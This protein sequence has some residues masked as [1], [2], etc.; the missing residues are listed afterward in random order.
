MFH[1]T[2][3]K[4]SLKTGELYTMTSKYP[5]HA[6]LW[7]MDGVLVNT[8]ELHYR[9]WKLAFDEAG[10]S[11]SQKKFTATFGMNNA[12]ILETVFGEDLTPD[13]YEKISNRKETSFRKMVKGNAELLPGADTLLEKFKT[14]SMKQAIAS[15]APQENI[16]VLVGE[17]KIGGYFDALISGTGMPGKPDPA[18]FLLAARKLD[19]EPDDC[20]VI[21]DAIAGVKGARRAGMKCI[22]VTTTNPAEALAQADY[23]VE[24]LTLVD[25]Q[26]ISALLDF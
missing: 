2:P 18:V 26:M 4:T 10:E 22:A 17:L 8:G 23:V 16:D 21:E 12:G 15:S 7:D 14:L 9:S 24:S 11:F 6:V 20:I 1:D 5:G 13:L 19:V 25:E 3:G